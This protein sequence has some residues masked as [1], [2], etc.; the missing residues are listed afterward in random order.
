MGVEAVIQPLQH[1][2]LCQSLGLVP[3][4]ALMGNLEVHKASACE[5]ADSSAICGTVLV[6]S[7][8]LKLFSLDLGKKKPFFPEDLIKAFGH[9]KVWKNLL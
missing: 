4:A 2:I 5:E 7:C 3:H 8:S 6:M 1:H 9:N